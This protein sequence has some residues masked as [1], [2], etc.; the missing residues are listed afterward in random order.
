MS[1]T[2]ISYN[3]FS[4]QD[5]NWKTRILRH[6]SWP[7]KS[8]DLEMRPRD[9]GFII[10]KTYLNQKR[11][12]VEGMLVC[13]TNADLR[14][15]LD[16]MKKA[17]RPK[18]KN[19]DIDYGGSTIRY[20]A[21]V[22]EIVISDDYY[23]ITALPYRILFLADPVGKSTTTN[24]ENYDNVTGSSYSNS[25][26]ITGSGNSKPTIKF[27]V[28]SEVDLT[29]IHFKNL[30]FDNVSNSISVSQSFNAADV[31]VIDCEEKT[32]Q[33]NDADV[34]FEGVFPVFTPNTNSFTLTLNST[35]HQIDLA[36]VY[37]P[38]YS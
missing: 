30:N 26:I 6:K 1:A 12:E 5:S 25:I 36:I 37:Y 35:S 27:T 2:S 33:V 20:T 4:L 3:S 31:L 16:N 11:I 8:I 17:L 9:D 29:K 34:D 15:K 19:L 24:S 28:D 7:E 18:E 22:E 38:S 14:T 23:H 21:S 32:V 13:S 10:V